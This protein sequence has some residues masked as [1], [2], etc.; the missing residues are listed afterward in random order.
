M[1][2]ADA[3]KWSNG[4]KTVTISLK[5]NYKWSNG[6]PM[7]ADDL[8]FFIDLVKAGIKISPANW[9]TYTPKF[10]PD[11]LVSTS[12][13]NSTTLVL[14]LKSP[15]NP[16]WFTEDILTSVNPIPS[17]L[18]AKTSA[19]G[20]AVPSSQW[21]N[22]STMA[23]IFKFLTAQSKSLN[24]Y[25]T[26][27]LWQVVNGPYKLSQYNTTTGAFTMVPNTSYGGPHVTPMS[28]FQAVAFTSDAAEF[29][30]VKS[31]SIDVGFIPAAN[32]PQLPQV[33]RLG[34][35]YFGEPD[36]GM[37][38]LNYNF[39]DKT[40]HF[41]SIVNQLYFRQA[42][43]HVEDQQG[44]IS[45][46]MHGAGAPAYGP[47][48]AY[49]KSPFLP[50]NAATNPYPFSVSSAV[51]LLKSHGWTVN[52]GGT[53]VCQNAGSGAS[54]CGAGIPAG[55]QLKFNLIYNSGSQLITSE[56]TDLVSKAKQAGIN[57][58]LQSSNFNYM[59]SNY[60]DP[61]APA[62]ANKWAMQ[63][64][65]GETNS[66]YPTTFSLFNTGGSNQ[67]G[68]YSNP[69][70]DQLINASITSSDPAAVKSEAAFLTTDQPVLF[71]P[72]NDRVWVW[73]STI[74]SSKPEAIESLT[75]FYANP[76]YWYF[77]S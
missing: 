27:P 72:N 70:A 14:N 32:I 21:N 22:A 1:S 55:T 9:A 19:T 13:P 33:L 53:D 73:K 75:Q 71:Q 62:N 65:G 36:F 69:K 7:T 20:S 74:S 12:E 18:W 38:F 10:F 56:M 76:E 57:I 42:M 45:A 30:A 50:S 54:Q 35:N 44:W 3:P 16:S 5:S 64:F 6:K 68:N 11:N 63:D 67:V 61:Y 8:L 77:N 29:N 37:N 51:S 58:T 48:P 15:V 47:I 25:A 49:P 24:T 34:Y 17:T 39:K 26:N 46:F 59:I 4:N 43:A 52:A 41:D 40:N 28:N 66:T 2:V 60:L 23:G 31:K